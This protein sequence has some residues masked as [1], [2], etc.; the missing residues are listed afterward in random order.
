[1]ESITIPRSSSGKIGEHLPKLEKRMRNKHLVLLVFTLFALTACGGTE[2][3]PVDSAAES[4]PPESTDILPTETPV[5]QEAGEIL[6]TETPVAQEAG[7]IEKEPSQV[8][9]DGPASECTL[10]SSLPESPPEY[11]ELFGL[12]ED[13]WVIGPEDA[14]VTLIEY[15]DFQ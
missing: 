3:T 8:S 13:D 4:P 12:T 6:P 5:A 10:V 2:R 9:M 14:A 1:V 7:E 11:A 15:G